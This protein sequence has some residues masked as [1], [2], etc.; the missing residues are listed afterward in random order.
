MRNCSEIKNKYKQMNNKNKFSSLIPNLFSWQSSHIFS[1][2]WLSSNIERTELKKNEWYEFLEGTHVRNTQGK[3]VFLISKKTSIWGGLNS[4]NRGQGK[5][6]LWRT[7]QTLSHEIVRKYTDLAAV[8]TPYPHLAAPSALVA[9]LCAGLPYHSG[10]WWL[11]QQFD[12]KTVLEDSEV[13][14]PQSS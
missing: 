1:S 5:A 14:W 9:M 7:Q 8:L 10:N 2:G 4:S 3:G 11:H 6:E 13:A 12:S